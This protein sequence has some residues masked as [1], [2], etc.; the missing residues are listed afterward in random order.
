MNTISAEKNTSV[1]KFSG[2]LF[3]LLLAALLVGLSFLL[4]RFT[5]PESI[6]SYSYADLS[7]PSDSQSVTDNI[8]M[9][10]VNGELT[11]MHFVPGE[12]DAQLIISY[13]ALE[14]NVRS[15]GLVFEETFFSNIEYELYYPNE[16]GDF[17][18]EK[19]LTGVIRRGWDRAF[20][21]L[22]EDADMSYCRFRIDMDSEFTL[23][24]VRLSGEE[25]S[26]VYVPSENKDN[27]IWA[28]LYVIY[29]GVLWIIWFFRKG[30][31]GF[32]KRAVS[33][34]KAWGRYVIIPLCA[35]IAGSVLL[36]A[37]R[38]VQ[39]KPGMWYE[40]SVVALV[41]MVLSFECILLFKKEPAQ[42]R[43]LSA[44]VKREG[45]GYWFGTL[46]VI[47]LAFYMIAD[48]LYSVRHLARSL[49]CL[50]PFALMLTQI[51]MFALLF[52]KYVIC[53][54]EG[55][56]RYLRVYIVSLSLL[57]LFYMIIFL[58]FL[59]P[60]E[61]THY[62]SAYRIADMMLGKGTSVGNS[63]M[64]LRAEDLE[65]TVS[66]HVGMSFEYLQEVVTGLHPFRQSSG[67]V[68]T[69]ANL[70]TN[71]LVCYLPAAFG[72]AIGRILNLSGTGV[73]YMARSMN[74]LL[75][76]GTAAYVMKKLKS[77]NDALFV[78]LAMPMVLQLMGSCSYDIV[79]VCFVML[80]VSQTICM[81]RMKSKAGK[82][83]LYLLILFAVLMAPAKVVYF[84]LLFLA[85]LIPGYVLGETKAERIGKKLLVIGS[86]FLAI[87]LLSMGIKWLSSATAVQ[88]MVAE[89]GSGHIVFWSGEE[90]YTISYIL[91]NPLSF[92]LL[93]G[94]TLIEKAD[95]FFFSMM[96]SRLARF[97]MVIPSV[98][99]L[100]CFLLFL[101]SINIR[102]EKNN[103]DM[104]TGQKIFSV[105]CCLMSAGGTVLAMALSWTPLSSEVILG[106]QGRYF[107][108]LLAVLIWVLRDRKLSSEPSIRKRVLFIT[109]MMNLWLLVFS[110]AGM[111]FMTALEA[112]KNA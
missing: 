88:Q 56:V 90:G 81:M 110:H 12:D 96:G 21:N 80:F 19:V 51:V 33:T 106:I 42:Q 7:M 98:C 34:R 74:L 64:I 38:L 4:Y 104:T 73:F 3:V 63:R 16:N 84:P 65:F 13:D 25:L 44:E 8:T 111:I 82:R 102:D 43:T 39:G 101:Q 11:G 87:F 1:K 78:F 52:R 100:I 20:F 61:T 57:A 112:M 14:Q 67:F 89:N 46:L 108:P 91:H 18:K 6:L 15:I 41:F 37:A 54:P 109:V 45:R 23:K 75:S 28:F 9:E 2:L 26:S 72:I 5:M 92:A 50:V 76:I 60:D 83:D 59:S 62:L 48:S 30:I 68:V 53:V 95:E 77:R 32:L 22:P 27:R 17:A 97:E 31:V 94:R 86:G 105:L 93:V 10:A 55:R 70:A 24:D 107:L 49:Q 35:G 29:V 36:K 58:P 85:C 69:D 40:Y 103:W 66:R 99:G 79:T 71:A 47:V